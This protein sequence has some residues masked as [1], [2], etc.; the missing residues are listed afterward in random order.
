MSQVLRLIGLARPQLRGFLAVGAIGLAVSGLYVAVG[1]IL[2]RAIGRIFDGS[3]IS[4][5]TGLLALA[6][7]IMLARAVALWAYARSAAA[8]AGDVKISLRQRLYRKVLELGPSWTSASRTGHV[9]GM[10]TDGVDA[11]EKV[12][13]G[14]LIQTAVSFIAGAIIAI[15]IVSVDP[16]VG[17][18]VLVALLGMPATVMLSKL[19]LKNTGELWWQAFGDLQATYVDHLQG[20]ATLKVF[21]ASQRRGEELHDRAI[22]FRDTAI[23]TMTRESLFSSYVGV[24]AG[25]G[26]A[27]SVGIGAL[28]VADGTLALA[29]L[30]LI[31]FLARECFRPLTDLTR[32]FHLAYYG[33]VVTAPMFALLDTSPQVAD[34][35]ADVTTSAASGGPAPQ[36]TFDVVS[37]RYPGGDDL[38]VRDLDLTVE[39]GETVALVGRSGAGKSTCAM[40]LLRFFDPTAGR[41]AI[42]GQDIRELTL[43]DLRS[44]IS[45]VAQD[46]HLFGTTVRDNLLLARPNA[47]EAELWT[48][49]DDAAAG[50]Y[51]RL[52]PEGLDTLIGE[53]GVKLS[54]GE[55]QRLSIARAL[56][57]DSPILVLDEATSSVD[58]SSESEIQAALDR[59]RV[60]RTTL[61]IAHRLSTVRGADRVV[62]LDDG[63]MVEQGRPGDLV[64]VNG[65]YARLVATQRGTR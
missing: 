48:V 23:A 11:V 6:A 36:V 61:V 4:D 57:K 64:T 12:Y 24:A 22:T 14:L 19:A 29:D 27:L 55:R 35:S 42:D 58:V 46:T 37:F 44:R 50:E 9:Q 34:T 2:A 13:S 5:I 3:Q 52:L 26:G 47:A 30:L 10:L 21:G 7:L 51:V 56:L 41:I 59:L 25:V 38:V 39:S 45:L 15:Y 60:G 33:I 54:G 8:V 62:V 18:V 63:A 40:L 1:V 28:H 65:A 53:R 32:G 16:V 20:I 31:L 49:L 43:A 17:T